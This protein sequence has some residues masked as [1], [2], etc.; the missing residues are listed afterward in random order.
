MGRA[1]T[2][3]RAAF[4]LPWTRPAAQDGNEADLDQG[5]E[6]R[7]ASA[8]RR[9]HV[10][11]DAAREFTLG[12]GWPRYSGARVSTTG[13]WRPCNSGSNARPPDQIQTYRATGARSGAAFRAAA[14]PLSR[15]RF[16]AFSIEAPSIAAALG[17]SLPSSALI[18]RRSARSSAMWSWNRAASVFVSKMERIGRGRAPARPAKP[19]SG[20]AEMRS[21]AQHFG[22]PLVLEAAARL[23]RWSHLRDA[24]LDALCRVSARSSAHP[25]T[26][27]SSSRS[28][29]AP[30]PPHS[31]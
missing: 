23:V 15:S 31:V 4:S 28:S 10:D 20:G 22:A 3:I 5:E 19:A 27:A 13:S 11:R 6:R 7:E 26:T 14:D 12:S 2:R 1:T 9:A 24:C 29:Q 30:S 25:G 8:A 16:R 17:E 18:A 21:G